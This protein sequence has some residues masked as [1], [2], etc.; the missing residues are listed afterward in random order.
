[1]LSYFASDPYFLFI[2]M[3]VGCRYR[4]VLLG[5]RKEQAVHLMLAVIV[6][7]LHLHYLCQGKFKLHQSSCLGLHIWISYSHFLVRIRLYDRMYY[8]ARVYPLKS[9]HNTVKDPG[10]FIRLMLNI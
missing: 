8:A 1:V 5:F 2:L 3:K 10:S 9:E 6:S 4:R 7:H